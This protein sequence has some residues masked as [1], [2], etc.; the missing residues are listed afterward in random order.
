MREDFPGQLSV[1]SSSTRTSNKMARNACEL[2]MSQQPEN[3]CLHIAK[4]KG[5]SEST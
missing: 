3:A 1:A 5:S 4:E 2:I